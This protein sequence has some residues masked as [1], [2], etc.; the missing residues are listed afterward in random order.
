M[1]IKPESRVRPDLLQG[2]RSLSSM[3]AL[4]RGTVIETSLL[5]SATGTEDHQLF[6]LVNAPFQEEF[7]LKADYKQSIA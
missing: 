4:A 3:A 6:G 5:L 2:V 1:R 7:I